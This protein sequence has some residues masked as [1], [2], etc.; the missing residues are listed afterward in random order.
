MTRGHLSLLCAIS[1]KVVNARFAVAR[2]VAVYLYDGDAIQELPVH[3]CVIEYH[4]VSS[5]SAVY[6]LSNS[7]RLKFALVRRCRKFL[8]RTQFINLICKVV[9]ISLSNRER[10]DF[11]YYLKNICYIF[12]PNSRFYKRWENWLE[13]AAWRFKIFFKYLITVKVVGDSREKSENL[14]IIK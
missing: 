1:H 10:Y 11:E 3:C 5:H 13:N 12:R 9:F 2:F 4:K 8:L 6:H 14:K 7:S